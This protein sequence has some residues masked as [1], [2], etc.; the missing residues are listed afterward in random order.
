MTTFFRSATPNPTSNS[1]FRP[2]KTF[3]EQ[4]ERAGG[5]THHAARYY[6]TGRP[7]TGSGA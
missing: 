3:D 5:E 1:D 2:F 6:G 4:G 7:S